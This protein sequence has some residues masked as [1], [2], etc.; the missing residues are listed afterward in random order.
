MKKKTYELSGYES[1]MIKPKELIEIKGSGPLTLQDRRVFNVLLNNAWG[2]S[3]INPGEE[4]TIDTTQLK[5]PGQT[6]QRLKRSLRRLMT[7]VI[8][9][10]KDNGDDVETQLLGSRRIT[11]SGTM[12]YSFPN[13]LAE[14]LKDSSVFAK[15]DLEVMRSFSS[16]Y[17]FALYEAI[18]RRIN[19]K[20]KFSEELDLEDMRELLGVEAGKLAAYRNLRIKAIEPAVAEVNAITPYH[21]TITPINKG[22]KVI[23]FKMHWYV[24][25]EAG[26]VKSYKELQSAKVGR[27]KRQEG[28]ADTI[29]ELPD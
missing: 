10:V 4:F 16:K 19:L 29:I 12:V 9:S 6:N 17:A 18:A 27:T 23:G 5:E 3:I 28:A 24:K 1:E 21:I 2:K 20:H 14:V 8:V 13:E 22:R 15:L 11:A 7:T 26:L 25:D